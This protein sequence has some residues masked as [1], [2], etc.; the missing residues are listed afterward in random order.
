MTQ[1]HDAQTVC[2]PFR[3]G[4]VQADDDCVYI[5]LDERGLAIPLHQA[6]EVLLALAAV[7]LRPRWGAPGGAG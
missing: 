1:Q 6:P 7:L 3:G 4:A 2:C 5:E